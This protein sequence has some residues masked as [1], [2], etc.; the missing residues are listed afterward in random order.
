MSFTLS[1]ICSCYPVQCIAE[2]FEVD[3]DSESDKAQYS[4]APASLLSLVDVFLKTKAKSA[5]QAGSSA[6]GPSS[7]PAPST[8][9]EPSAADKA[10]AEELKTK[11]NALM[12]QKMYDSAIEQYTQAIK[13][14][15]NPVY[16][17]NRAAAW[18]GVGEHEKA[19]EDAERALALD[20]KFAKAYSRLG[21]V[22]PFAA[23]NCVDDPADTPNS[24]LESI[25]LPSK[26][27]SLD[28]SSIP[29]TTI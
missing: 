27:M 19:V 4:L 26:R 21:Q 10:K 6:P 3:P 23:L 29:A 7:A 5:P 20:P 2:A 16:Y 8:G 11:G 17:S 28:S 13:L 25:A 24:P 9:D 12:G 18:G 1:R 15:P 14:D 22:Y